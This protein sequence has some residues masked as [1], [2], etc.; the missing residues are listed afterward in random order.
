[1]GRRR[2]RVSVT[3]AVLAAGV[4]VV[5]V[6]AGVLTGTGASS[7]AA[8]SHPYYLSLGDSYSIGY[9][10][11][12][13]GS[14][15]TPGYT[16]Y[17]ADA[18]SLGLENF[19]CGGATT[20]SLLHTV[21]CG[22]PAAQHAVDYPRSTQEQA[23]L[24][25]IAAHPGRVKL[26]TVS[27]GG[28]DFDGCS[29]VTCVKGAMSGMGTDIRTLVKALSTALVK[30][31]DPHATVIG[32]TYPDV[33]LGLYVYPTD[34]GSSASLSLA[35]QSVLAFDDLINPTLKAAYATEARD[36]FVDVTTA[37]WH[38]ATRGADTNLSVTETLAPYGTVP[39][40]VGEVCQ[41]TYFCSQGN[42]HADTS[43][44]NFIGS[45]IVASERAA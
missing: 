11:G 31:S 42:I 24:T 26:I 23:A 38:S 18:L 32:I 14:G 21:G 33:D 6:L 37:P 22:D 29:S 41:L 20:S 43:G 44:Y 35:R 1:M 39:V 34:P 10:P 45:L 19:G 36:R 5:A 13:S 15:G 7:A 30:A 17:V 8:P 12:V 3:A 40:A 25:F 4:V 2:H 16:A 28:N 27:I 9:Q